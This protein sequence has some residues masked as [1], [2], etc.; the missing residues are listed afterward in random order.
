MSKLAPV[1]FVDVAIEDV[2][3]RVQRPA[4][5]LKAMAS[6]T[7]VMIA[8]DPSSEDEAFAGHVDGAIAI[9]DGLMGGAVV[10]GYVSGTRP[11]R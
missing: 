8:L 10:Y 7:A 4:A 3:P 2:T 1:R 11:P 5:Q 6:N 9:A